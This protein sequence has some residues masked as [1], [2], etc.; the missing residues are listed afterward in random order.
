MRLVYGALAEAA[1]VRSDG[2]MVV[3]GVGLEAVTRDTFP[4]PLPPLFVACQVAFERQD[5]PQPHRLELEILF[6]GK[7][8]PQNIIE[9][10]IPARPAGEQ[11]DIVLPFLFGLAGVPIPHPGSLWLQLKVD[12]KVL[13]QY[14]LRVVERTSEATGVSALARI[15]NEGYSQFQQG[16]LLSAESTFRRAVDEFPAIGA[17]YN[18]LGFVLLA[19]GQPTDALGNFEHAASS[20]FPSPELLSMNLGCCRYLLG[21]FSRA[22]SHFHECLEAQRLSSPATLFVLGRTAMEAVAVVSAADFAALAAVNLSRVQLRMGNRD[23]AQ[24]L[25]E[26][27][28]LGLLT[29]SQHPASRARFARAVQEL[30]EDL[31]VG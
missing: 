23:I 6:D 31:A 18:N 16:D 7:P 13:A 24:L 2:K 4:G 1:E 11:A 21:D 22:A 27:S 3:T 20:G 10:S 17:G 5:F 29:F 14:H 15:L 19:K 26:A 8:V 9:T 25:A 28:R 30:L 12:A